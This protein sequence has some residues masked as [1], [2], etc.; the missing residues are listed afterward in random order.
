MKTL[1]VNANDKSVKYSH[2][3]QAGKQTGLRNITLHGSINMGAN[4]GSDTQTTRKTPN[5]QECGPTA[6]GDDG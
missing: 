1:V 2:A 4:A 6:L 5:E 3:S